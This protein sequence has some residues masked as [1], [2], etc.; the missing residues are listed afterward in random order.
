MFSNNYGLPQFRANVLRILKLEGGWNV[1]QVSPDQLE[2]NVDEPYIIDLLGAFL[3]AMRKVGYGEDIYEML[4]VRINEV[5]YQHRIGYR[6][7]DG[8]VLSVK[9]DELQT[10][11][12]EPALRLLISNRFDA[13]QVAYLKAI[14]EVSAGH[15]D[16]AIT[17]AGTALAEVLKALGCSGTRGCCTIR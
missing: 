9:T 3:A 2:S 13:A 6:V 12:V 8:E 4:D 7:V 5:F 10:E 11:V 16:D 1:G 17:D 14:K 15:P